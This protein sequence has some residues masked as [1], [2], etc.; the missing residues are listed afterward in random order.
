MPLNTFTPQD[1]FIFR[2]VI[3]ESHL[4]LVGRRKWSSCVVAI[5]KQGDNPTNAMK[6]YK[7]SHVLNFLP[8]ELVNFVQF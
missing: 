4:L 1:T 5:S 8:I 6:D 2:L 3:A 7:E